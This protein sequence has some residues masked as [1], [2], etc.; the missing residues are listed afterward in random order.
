MIGFI[1]NCAQRVNNFCANPRPTVA[2]LCE[3]MQVNTQIWNNLLFISGGA[4]VL[5][6]CS[7]HL[8]K[9]NWKHDGQK[10]LK[11]GTTV[12]PIYILNRLVQS[13]VEQKLNFQLLKTLGCYVNPAYWVH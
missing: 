1:N 6:K 9:S 3:K 2:A 7:F 10:F 5:P 8:T 11:V 13:Q 12:P 4:L